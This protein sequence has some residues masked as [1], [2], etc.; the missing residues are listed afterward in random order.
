MEQ[1][2]MA[3]TQGDKSGVRNLSPIL[4]QMQS[5]QKILQRMACS[6]ILASGG[7]CSV[8]IAIIDYLVGVYPD[9]TVL[10]I[11]SHLDANTPETSPSGNLHGMPVAAIMGAAPKDMQPIL[12]HPLSPERFRYVWA[13][14][15]DEGD[16]DFQKAKG[17]RW[18]ADNER[19][20]GPIHIH[21]DLDVLHPGEF[22]FL[23]Y[24]E[25]TGMPIATAVSLLQRIAK[26]GD[27]VGLTFTEFAPANEVDARSGSHT[28]S[29]L[30]DIIVASQT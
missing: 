30:C 18:L 2:T 5:A 21:F 27:I 23:A 26:E 3:N 14:V 24:P 25:E 15:G 4:E 29:S 10:W 17:L 16:Y 7:D 22:P 6:K 8:D 12:L 9:L 13:N 1:V 11:D 19:V 28:I 20:S